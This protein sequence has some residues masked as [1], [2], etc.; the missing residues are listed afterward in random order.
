MATS[1]VFNGKTRKEPGVYSQIKS[2]VKNPPLALSFGNVL[3]IDTGSGASYGAGPGINGTISSGKDAI[4]VFDNIADF[5]TF[6]GG[7]LWWLLASPLFRPNGPGINGASLIHYVKA[8]TTVPG[9]LTYTFVGGG[10]NGGVLN[11]RTKAEG[12]VANAFEGD[13]TN[14]V[15]SFTVATA[16]LTDTFDVQ[17]DEGSGAASIGSYVVVSIDTS[18]TATGIADA[19]NADSANYSAVAVADLVTVTARNA[20]A[21][22]DNTEWN[23]YPLTIVITGTSTSSGLATFAGGVDGTLLT[24]GYAGRMVVGSID[25]TK[26]ALEFYRGTFKGLDSDGDPFDSLAEADT[27]ATLLI[28]SPEF[29]NIQTVIDWM[30]VNFTFGQH[31]ELQTSTKSGTGAVDTA[32]LTVNAGHNKSGGGTEAYSTSQ[33]DNVLDNV[34]ELDYTFVLSDQ[35]GSSATGADNG[36]ILAHLTDEARFD[37]FMVVAGG[38]DLDTYQS[39]SIAAAQFYDTDKVLVIHGGPKIISRQTSTG[40]K[41]RSALYKAAGVLGRVCGLEPQVPVTFKA[42]AI[43]GE[44][45][46]MKESERVESLDNGVLHTRFDSD[47]GEFVVNQGITTLQDNDFLINENGT[48][49][50]LAVK[51]IAA[52]L[53]KEIEVNA[54][55]QLLAKEDGTNRNTLSPIDVERWLE[56]YLTRKTATATA[57]N[58]ILSFQDISVEVKQDA[59][60]I[61]YGF[62]PNFP[63][64]K[65][66]FTGFILDPNI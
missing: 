9:S 29:D 20:I 25:A 18:I 47:L 45:H 16:V 57:D 8:A 33:L 38:D 42:L 51:R 35:G 52:Q 43:D 53:N 58:L 36:K 23:A 26:F 59:Y 62:V 48:S 44:R 32:D 22:E 3:V 4:S 34:P 66:F 46:N 13:G 55:V 40:F 64:N 54:K 10:G 7:G 14:A 2:G 63:V 5:R 1:F 6:I 56:G 37:K 28:K 50:E 15:G 61:N 39:E 60:F 21:L 12:L 49:H 27:E 11:L 30:G 41:N 31:F 19:I 65:L 24:R 17:V